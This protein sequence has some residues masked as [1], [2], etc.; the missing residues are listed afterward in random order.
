MP[1]GPRQQGQGWC[2]CHGLLVGV[3]GAEYML[4]L[5]PGPWCAATLQAGVTC[6][7][8]RW[9]RETTQLGTLRHS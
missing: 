4:S 6:E 7:S 8:L 2:P 1:L 3:G 5:R 9:G